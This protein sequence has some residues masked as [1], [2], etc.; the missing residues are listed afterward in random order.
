V[1][2]HDVIEHSLGEGR[3]KG[4]KM[5]DG[6]GGGVGLRRGR[7]E[8]GWAP[9]TTLLTCPLRLLPSHHHHRRRRRQVRTAQKGN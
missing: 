7:E 2:F 9:L 4:Q 3:T 1:H 5:G 8:M 6:G